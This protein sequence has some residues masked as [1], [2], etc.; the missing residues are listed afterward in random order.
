ME[1]TYH[2]QEVEAKWQKYWTDHKLFQALEDKNKKKFYILEMFPYPSGRLH[3]GHVRNYTLGDLINRYRKMRGF[4]VLHPIGW[5]AFGLPAENAAI[6][7]KIHPEKW[8]KDNIAYMAGQLKKMGIGYD[9]SREFATCD[10][11]YYKWNQW[12][13]IKLMEKG[14]VYRKKSLVNFCP[15]CETVLANEQV[16][17]GLCWRCDNEVHQKELEQWY[18][19]TTAYTEEIL[20]G[21]ELIKNGWAQKVLA[22]QE[23]WIGKSYGTEIDFP[24]VDRDQVIKVFTTRPDTLCGVTYMVLAPEHPLVEELTAG[25]K[26]AGEVRA[27]AD[28]VKKQNKIL[29]VSEEAKKEGMFIGAYCQNPITNDKVPI[30]IANYVLLEYG[31]GAVMAV[32]AHDIR[33]FA[34]AKEY[35][36]PIKEVISKDGQPTAGGLKEAYIDEGLMINSGQFNGSPNKEGMDKVTAFLAQGKKGKKV[37]NYR[38]RDWLISRQRFWGTPIPVVYC[39]KCGLVPVA[40]QDLPVVLP[41][42][43]EF[44]GKGESPLSQVAEFVNTTCPKC[45]G[46]AKRETDTMDTFVDSSWYFARYCDARN[47]QLPFSREKA[48]YWL[49]VDQYIGGAEHACMHLIYSRFFFKVMRDMGLLKG[50]E[51]FTNLLNQGMV[52]LG[53]TAMSK[54]KGNIVDPDH[55]IEKYGADTMRLFILFASPPEK[56]LEYSD[57]GVE[58]AW[59]FLTRIWRLVERVTENPVARDQRN[60]QAARALD[61]KVHA[62]VKKVTNDLEKE[63]GFN[64]AIAALME[65]VN[66]IHDLEP[67]VTADDIRKA[68]EKVV[69]LIAPFTPHIAAEMWQRLGQE[70]N[71]ISLPWPAYDESAIKEEAIEI[72]VQVNGK[73]R[74]RVSVRPGVPEEEVKRLA[75]E[76]EKVK[77]Q[78]SGKK[79]IKIVYVPNKLVNIVVA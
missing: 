48:D 19:K 9:W 1:Q 11:G 43:V 18:F 72:V 73:V 28:K 54:S 38:F 7:N 16:E 49:P 53:G 29:R 30:W 22:M 69:I 60:E 13:F 12:F 21:H 35:K 65:L 34:F 10:P 64:T 23:N 8:T 70:E 74:G 52:T 17:Q 61:R 4:N 40:E 55:I 2:P 68:A 71:L 3:M 79:I 63:F 59:R 31:T 25:T 6:K 62:T 24:L 37:V 57:T 41:K 67:Q 32:P 42:N 66:T 33:D 56:D 46:P 39:E 45:Q 51:P 15:S 76:D 5:D 26:L 78:V 50:D 77:A 36:L 27:F 20:S 44:T 47:E 75:A 14:L 58:G